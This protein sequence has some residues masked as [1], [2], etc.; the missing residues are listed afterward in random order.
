RICGCGA[1]LQMSEVSVG[2]MPS[3]QQR[4]SAAEQTTGFAGG[5]DYITKKPFSGKCR[6]PVNLYSCS[7]PVF[8][9]PFSVFHFQFS[10][11]NFPFSILNSNIIS[12]SSH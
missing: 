3:Q 5:F 12:R 7:F 6:K 1:N 4:L 11:F 10:I 8:N 9:F 2:S